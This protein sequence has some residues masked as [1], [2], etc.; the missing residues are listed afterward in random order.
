VSTASNLL[1]TANSALAP[2]LRRL[3]W[4]EIDGEY[5]RNLARRSREEDLEGAGLRQPPPRKG[6]RTTEALGLTGSG[7]A[8]LVNR[9]PMIICGLGLAPVLLEEFGG[10]VAFEPNYRDGEWVESG[11]KLSQIH[12][13]KAS[14]LATER[15]L[16]NF[17]QRLSGIATLAKQFVD[18]LDGGQARLLDTRKTTPGHRVLEKYAVAT[19]GG[20]NHRFGLF[21]RVMIKDNH[22]AASNAGQGQALAEAIS[23][24]KEHAPDLLIQLEIDRLDQI[25]PA[26]EA[27]VDALLLD[28]FSFD[29]LREG[30]RIIDTVAITEASG[31]ITLEKASRYNEIDI[32]FISTSALIGHAAW[33]D[34]GLDWLD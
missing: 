34:V 4:D 32:D 12:G 31:G 10:G 33:S 30:A 16:L 1:S 18:A 23:K 2:F 17:V 29:D 26:L 21:D 20:W 14:I 28:N 5:L 8:A 25:E 13:D 19:G 3:H 15:S 22:L 7:R 6:D 27:K 11:T 9:E 24:A